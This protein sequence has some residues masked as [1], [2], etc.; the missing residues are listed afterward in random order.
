MKIA[1]IGGTGL[2]GSKVIAQ[3]RNNGHEAIAA[4]PNTG[5][6]TLTGEGLKEALTGADVVV[7]VSNSPS[8]EATAL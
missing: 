2:V 8:F 4:A 6:N 1:V 7:D 3:L 5:V